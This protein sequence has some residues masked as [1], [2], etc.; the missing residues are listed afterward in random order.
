MLLSLASC[1]KTETSAPVTAPTPAPVVEKA[2]LPEKVETEGATGIRIEAPV[3][4]ME[5]SPGTE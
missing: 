5:A 3:T 2:T 4:P 1:T